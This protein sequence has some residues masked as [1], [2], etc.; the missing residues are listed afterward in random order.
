MQY[1]LMHDAFE[2]ALKEVIQACGGPKAIGREMRPELPVEQAAGWVRDC[3]NPEKRDK[4]SMQ[5][6]R[7]ILRRGRDVGAH[8]GRWFAGRKLARD[9]GYSDPSPLDPEDEVVRMQREFVEAT[10]QLSR[11]ADRIAKIQGADA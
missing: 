6:V 7:F 8:A 11:L 1:A 3:L 4:F 9:A 5:H 2:D 10:K